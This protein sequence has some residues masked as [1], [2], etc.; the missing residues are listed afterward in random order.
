MTPRPAPAVNADGRKAGAHPTQA[1]AGAGSTADRHRPTYEQPDGNFTRL[2]LTLT[3]TNALDAMA[4]M[5]NH[6]RA[7][8]LAAAGRLAVLEPAQWAQRDA[9]GKFLRPSVLLEIYWR[10]ADA[11][12]RHATE[13]VKVGIAAMAADVVRRDAEQV[14][15]LLQALVHQLGRRWDEDEVQQALVVAYGRLETA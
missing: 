13:C 7:D 14:V 12:E 15:T 8:F 6:R 9:G 1:P 5:L 11:Y 2:G 4:E 3:G 10:C